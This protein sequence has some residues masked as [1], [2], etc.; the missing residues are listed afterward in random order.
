MFFLYVL[1]AIFFQLFVYFALFVVSDERDLLH[2]L[3]HVVGDELHF[4]DFLLTVPDGVR[5]LVTTV[6]TEAWKFDVAYAY[7]FI[8]GEL[9]LDELEE[10]LIF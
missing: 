7:G 3:R 6:E 4:A 5:L 8:T 1:Y 2:A 9:V 10:N